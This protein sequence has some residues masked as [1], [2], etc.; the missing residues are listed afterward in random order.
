MSSDP[1][2]SRAKILARREEFVKRS[3]D[4]EPGDFGAPP[5]ICL[6]IGPS[7][8]LSPARW[9]EPK[10]KRISPLITIGVTILAILLIAVVLHF[11][12]D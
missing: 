10:K 4:G 8:C 3:M 5:E 12:L 9:D 2:D 11:V 7:V 1:P 6:S